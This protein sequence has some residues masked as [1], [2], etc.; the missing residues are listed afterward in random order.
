L[1][2]QPPSSRSCHTRYHGGVCL[3]SPRE[4]EAVGC[5]C[6]YFSM[7]YMCFLRVS[8]LCVLTCGS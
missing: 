4:W 3:D 7:P 2:T 8:Q 6:G 1:P 5:Q